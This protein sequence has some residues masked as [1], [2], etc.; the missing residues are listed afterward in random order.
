VNSG[1][2][3]VP[4]C[5]DGANPKRLRRHGVGCPRTQTGIRLGLVALCPQ[6][7]AGKDRG[8]ERGCQIGYQA[9]EIKHVGE[10]STACARSAAQDIHPFKAGEYIRIC[11][12][13]NGVPLCCTGDVLDC[14]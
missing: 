14:R 10:I 11:A 1:G 6:A 2:L 12:S 4:Y 13:S 7:A 9:V 5:H 8:H 3:Q